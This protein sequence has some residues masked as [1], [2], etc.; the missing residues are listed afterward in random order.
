[1][2]ITMKKLISMVCLALLV[3]LTASAQEKSE[4]K[5]ANWQDKVRA[6]RVGFLTTELD[7]S[8]AEAQAFWPVYNALQQER[9]DAFKAVR[10]ATKALSEALKKGEGDTAALLDDYL[11]AREKTAAL[12]S[13][14][15]R[16]EQQHEIRAQLGAYDQAYN[17]LMQLMAEKDSVYLR[18]QDEDVAIL[19]AE[20]DNASLREE[21]ERQKTRNQFLL[22]GGFLL[23]F[24]MAFL[25][26]LFH[27]WR[28][29][30]NLDQMRAQ[31]NSILMARRAYRQ[32]LDAQEAE[33][34]LKIKL[35]QNK[36][37]NTIPL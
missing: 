26:V 36:Q 18:I 2:R 28:V 11:K 34:A 20:M 17:S 19:E 27:H 3:A 9:R 31:Q 32:A 16:L 4:K 22:M 29:R 14:R 1:M 12:D 30:D 33:N 23:M 10:S 5:G 15:E 25:A 35:L 24:M 13:S 6:E 8:E 21:A 7:L 37:Y